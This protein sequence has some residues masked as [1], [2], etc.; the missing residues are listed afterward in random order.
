MEYMDEERLLSEEEQEV[1]DPAEEEIVESEENQ[2]AADPD[3]EE[4]EHQRT[5]ADAAFARMRRDLEESRRNEEAQRKQNERFKDVLGRFGF[6][7]ENAE[8][9]ADAAQAHLEGKDI[10]DIRNSRIAKAAEENEISRLRAENESLKRDAAAQVFAEDLAKIKK[11]DP[12][13]KSIEDLG[14]EF[15]KLRAAGISCETAF[16]AIRK[17][18]NA[19]KVQPPAKMGR[20]NGK[21][22]SDKTFYSPEEVDRLTAEDYDKPGVMEAVMKSMT[23]WK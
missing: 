7:G 15:A 5:E 22:A 21:T 17:T 1:A 23:K 16:N 9:V 20:V 13:V 19:E 10:A 11:L 8:D 2:E 12:S 4:E 3:M 6:N 18:E 14:V